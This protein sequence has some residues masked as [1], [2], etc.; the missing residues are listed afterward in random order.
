MRGSWLSGGLLGALALSVVAPVVAQDTK[1]KAPAAGDLS[2]KVAA[3]DEMR[4]AFTWLLSQKTELKGAMPPQEQTFEV[5]YGLTEKVKSVAAEGATIEA[6]ISSIRGRVA[7]GMMG[8]M[9]YDSAEADDPNNT[10]RWMRH[11]VGKTFTFVL[12]PNGEVTSVTGGDAL[13]ADVTKLIEKD[14]AEQPKRGPQ[15]GGQGGQGGMGGG[16]DDPMGGMGVDPAQLVKVMAGRLTVVFTDESLKS[17]LTVMNNV[18]PDEAKKENDTWSRPVREL[19]PQI[20]SIAFTTQFTHRG[21]ADKKTRITSRNDG[22][23]QF[24]K[25]RADAGE[26]G[27]QGDPM[28]DMMRQMQREMNEGLQV[29]RK[30]AT[31]TA[32][33]DGARGRLVDSELV[34]EIE[35][36][37]P[38]PAMMKAMMGDQAKDMKMTQS[39]TLTLRYVE[40]GQQ[41]GF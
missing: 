34:H 37:G 13:R 22:E 40:Q 25:E 33:W 10:M 6:T 2:W 5:S 11:L 19:V 8:D 4:Y 9:S 41:G 21:T 15:G 39:T 35:M 16:D 20:G 1:T 17:S 28:Q 29:K 18:L 31:G 24:E 30:A 7:L 38:L 27:E 32:S 26:G 3:N 36:E 14:L 23:I 12:K